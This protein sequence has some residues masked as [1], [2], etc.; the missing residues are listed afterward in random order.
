VFVPKQL[1]RQRLEL[2]NDTFKFR[3]S[4]APSRHNPDYDWLQLLFK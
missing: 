2:K 3:G 4:I 1:A